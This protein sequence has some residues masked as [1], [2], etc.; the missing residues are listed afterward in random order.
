[1]AGDFFSAGYKLELLHVAVLLAITIPQFI[2]YYKSGLTERY[3]LPLNLGF[4]FFILFLVR[5][6]NDNPN[7]HLY[8]KKSYVIIIA[9]ACVYCLRTQTL[10]NAISFTQ[11][12]KSTN[13]FL[14]SITSQ[15]SENDS[16]LVVLNGFENYE[17]GHSIYSYLTLKSDR[18]NI[19]F[20]P[21]K[22]PLEDD[23]E[24]SLDADFSNKFSP[25]ISIEITPDFACV[26]VMPFNTN[27]KIKSR[28]SAD[29]CYEKNEFDIFT[30]YARKR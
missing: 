7:I 8:F 16:L 5:R 21:A 19:F 27:Q 12:G 29:T 20:L 28:L 22:Q 2:L 17:W 24:R 26:A 15:T 10:P 4:S 18:K 11:E 14:S 3:L 25:L 1:M 23:F 6:I 9:L 13:A 30:V